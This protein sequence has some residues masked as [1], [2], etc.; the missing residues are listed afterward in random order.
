MRSSTLGSSIYAP[1][2]TQIIE[3]FDV[4]ATVAILPLSFYVLALGFGPVL[5]APISETYGRRVVYLLSPP[6]GALFTMGAGFSPSLASLVILRFFAGL[7]FSPAGAIG[8]GTVADCNPPNK[9]AR[10]TALYILTPF[11]GPALG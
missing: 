3:K 9:R 5:A 1:A 6:L 8:A 10:P 11:L 2:F 4:S 7:F